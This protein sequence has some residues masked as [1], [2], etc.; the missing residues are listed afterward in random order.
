M[1]FIRNFGFSE[2]YASSLIGTKLFFSDKAKM[3]VNWNSSLK[4]HRLAA[5]QSFQGPNLSEIPKRLKDILDE[6]SASMEQ[7]TTPLALSQHKLA[8]VSD[9]GTAA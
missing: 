5:L 9:V 3:R 4:Y 6:G 7:S 2:L 1:H 8:F